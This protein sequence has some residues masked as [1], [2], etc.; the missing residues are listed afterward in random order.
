MRER[1]IIDLTGM[2]MALVL[3]VWMVTGL[4]LFAQAGACRFDGAVT[5]RAVIYRVPGGCF[6]R[7]AAGD[8]APATPDNRPW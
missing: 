3:A 5:G 2:A 4:V 7:R 6:V 1:T 8:W